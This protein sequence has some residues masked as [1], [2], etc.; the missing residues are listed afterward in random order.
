MP[1]R[2]RVALTSTPRA[3]I[4]VA[5]HDDPPG[6]DRLEEID[7]AQ[8]GRL[9]RAG[10]ADQADDVVLGDRE[11]DP[12]QHLELAEALVQRLDAGCLPCAHASTAGLPAPRSRAVS[13]S[14]NR[15][16]GNREQ[17]EDERECDVAA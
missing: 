10:R 9:A 16:S 6:I 15:A 4:S 11:V 3:V 7:A 14:T 17:D 12:L 8:E 13:Q 1:T 5:E 2:R